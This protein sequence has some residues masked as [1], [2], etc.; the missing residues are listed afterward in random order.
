MGMRR[1]IIIGVNGDM[2]KCIRGYLSEVGES[3]VVGIDMVGGRDEEVYKVVDDVGYGIGEVVMHVCISFIDPEMFYASVNNYISRYVP[4][5]II[6]YSDKVIDG[7]CDRLGEN[8]VYSIMSREGDLYNLF[9]V[10]PRVVIG[11]RS[12]VV[13][14]MFRE[15]GMKVETFGNVN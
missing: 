8:V 5:Y 6:I 15:W 2:G 11:K 14:R 7:V 13:G 1:H 4:T 9:R 12:E 10:V 3:E